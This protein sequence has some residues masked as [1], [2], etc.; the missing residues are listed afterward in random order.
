MTCIECF[1]SNTELYRD[2]HGHFCKRCL[3]CEYDW[4]PFISPDRLREKGED[5]LYPELCG[6]I[7]EEDDNQASLLDF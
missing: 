1:S 2:E 5:H 6:T 3:D 4:G 7:E